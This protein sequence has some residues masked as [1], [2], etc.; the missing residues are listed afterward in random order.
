LLQN[1]FFLEVEVVLR[2][3]LEEVVETAFLDHPD[4]RPDHRIPDL[5]NRDR[6]S[7]LDHLQNRNRRYG[8]DHCENL[9]HRCENFLSLRSRDENFRGDLNYRDHCCCDRRH[10]RQIFP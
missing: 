8:L 10:R 6:C 4:H 7:D 3:A 1:L 2:N 5:Q 9:N